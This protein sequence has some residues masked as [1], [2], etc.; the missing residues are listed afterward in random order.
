LVDYVLQRFPKSDWDE[1]RD[2]V[3]RSSEAIETFIEDG[4]DAA[5]NQYNG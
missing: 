3:I 1:L 2:I 4:I 5:M